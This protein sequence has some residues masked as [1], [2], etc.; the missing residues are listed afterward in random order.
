[1]SKKEE[2]GEFPKNL[3]DKSAGVLCASCE[4]Y[5]SKEEIL[6]LIITE[7]GPFC[8]GRKDGNDGCEMGRYVFKSPFNQPKSALSSL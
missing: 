2:D 8:N 1:M 6:A 5:K 7:R 4:Y 3:S